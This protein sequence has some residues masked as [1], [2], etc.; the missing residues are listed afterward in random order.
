MVSADTRK[1]AY[2]SILNIIQGDVDPSQVH[3]A[4]A[5]V[6]EKRLATF[7]PWGPAAIQVC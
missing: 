2:I 1:G 6:R 7:V 5:A 4:L 3:K